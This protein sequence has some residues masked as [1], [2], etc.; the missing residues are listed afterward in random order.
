[1]L[2]SICVITY[3]RPDGLKRL[4]DGL[5]RLNFKKVRPPEIE[6]VVVD[7]DSSGAA[8]DY[9]E[10]I[11]ASFQWTLRSH[12]EPQR[13]ISNARNS[14]IN[15]ASKKTDFF[16]LIDDDE[17]PDPLW[18][19]ELLFVQQE[20]N[21][22]VVTGPVVPCFGDENVPDWVE[23]G[24]FF[25]PEHHATGS[26]RR[27]A[28]TNNVLFRSSI[29]RTLDKIFDE[30]FALTGGE[31]TDF[32]MRA[33]KNGARIIWSDEAL[34]YEWVPESRTKASWILQRGYRTWGSHSLIEKELYPTLGVRA[35][36]VAKGFGLIAIGVVLLVPSCFMGRHAQVRA[37]LNVSRGAGT[38]SG[39]L[40]LRYR[41]YAK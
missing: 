21:A 6:V 3:R 4:L 1:M 13:G 2:V 37:L 20:Y 40:G 26:E 32:F 28:F 36:R 12:V 18:L 14:A 23:K 17:V 10:R 9:C 35:A 34:V 19:D 27:V 25:A 16:A 11:R 31:D 33:F 22:D 15:F 38:F 8:I 30:R 24:A 39:L 7:N 41:E 29:L 5:H